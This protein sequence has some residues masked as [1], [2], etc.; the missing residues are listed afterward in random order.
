MQTVPKLPS[1]RLRVFSLICMKNININRF[2]QST[3]KAFTLLGNLVLGVV[4]L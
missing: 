1:Q 2:S 3:L 4:S